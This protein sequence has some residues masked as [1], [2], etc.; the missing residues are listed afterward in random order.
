MAGTGEGRR[1]KKRRRA[2]CQ[3]SGSVDSTCGTASET[4]PKPGYK[5]PNTMRHSRLQEVVACKSTKV[6]RSSRVDTPSGLSPQEELEPKTTNGLQVFIG[7]VPYGCTAEQLRE[8][9]VTKGVKDIKIDVKTG[10]RGRGTAFGVCTSQDEFDQAMSVHHT[11]FQGRK[12]VVEAAR[13][14]PKASSHSPGRYSSH[15]V[16]IG[17]IPYKA[18]EEDIQK[19]MV[20]LGVGKLSIR[21]L[22]DRK[23]KKSR[24][25]AF[26][27]C[28]NEKQLV[29]ALRA[30]HSTLFGKVI[31]VERT[32]GG[33]GKGTKRK[34]R[35]CYLREKQGAKVIKDT[36]ELVANVLTET[37]CCSLSLQDFDDRAIGKRL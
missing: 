23:T 22:T 35:L 7:Q 28:Q 18:T 4:I 34:E 6:P 32:V 24:G 10:R 33:G 31:N 3:P 20:S 16:F 15:R 1:S 37:E 26:A 11:Y 21:L 12:L 2:Q 14:V 19:H 8:H 17:Q 29:R 9:F 5:E 30:H 25:I 13:S 27:D 36:R